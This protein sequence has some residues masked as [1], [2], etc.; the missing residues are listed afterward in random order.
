MA[1]TKLFG[2]EDG[3]RYLQRAGGAGV[4]EPVTFPCSSE[5][6][7]RRRSNLPRPRPTPGAVR[8][9][10]SGSKADRTGTAET[11][12]ASQG[13]ERTLRRFTAAGLP[14]HFRPRRAEDWV[15]SPSKLKAGVLNPYGTR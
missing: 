3:R 4:A 1:V 6:E 7:S 12:D 11:L 13:H 15:T 14:D 9:E 8:L 5:R 2:A 10:Q